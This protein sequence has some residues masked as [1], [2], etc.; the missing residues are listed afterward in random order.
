MHIRNDPSFF[1]MNKAGAPHGDELGRIKP[2]SDNSCSCLDNSFI[3]DGAKR[4]GA[5]ATGAAPGIRQYGIQL[6]WVAEVQV[7]LREIPQENLDKLDIFYA[8]PSIS[9]SVTFE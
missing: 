4:Y 8:S 5:R 7:I 2:F 6:A 1:F 3:S 9:C